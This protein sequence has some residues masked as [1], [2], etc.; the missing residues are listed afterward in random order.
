M[1]G[2]EAE[3]NEAGRIPTTHAG[4]LP[5]PEGLL[6]MLLSGE[7]TGPEF[8]R[9]VRQAVA[10]A[11]DR[12]IATGIDVVGDGEQG[13]PSFAT[14]VTDRLTGFE[15]EKRPRPNPYEARLF[16]ELYAARYAVLGVP[17]VPACAGPV[18]WRGDADVQADIA[19]LTSALSGRAGVEAFMTSASPGVVWYYQPNAFYPTHEKYIE[20]VA[21]AMQH[22]YNAIHE[23]GFLLQLDSPD[24]AGGWNRQDFGDKTVEDFRRFAQLHI[25]ALNY[26]TRAIPPE[27]MRLH[28]C[29]GNLE[30]P[31]TRD[32]PLAAIIDVLL[33]ARPAALSIEGANPRH[34]HEWALFEEVRLPDEK[35]L[36]PG[37]IDTT[38]NFVE[39]PE[40]V[41]RRIEAYAKVAGRDR[42]VAGTDCGFS[43]LARRRLPVHPTVVWAKL[44]SLVEGARIASNR[45]WS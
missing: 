38:T 7:R 18:T 15:G 22:E 42:L 44:Q 30:V 43:T 16:P 1:G 25:E 29:W 21:E 3:V 35:T 26:A 6:E 11:V 27:R 45:L 19:A 4:S 34:A 32:I 20:A 24:L 36:I 23:A 2:A 37:V 13:K 33:T 28:V 9:A 5:R 31:H 41:A 39:H 8:E 14:Y 17:D 40:L 12:Q 10:D